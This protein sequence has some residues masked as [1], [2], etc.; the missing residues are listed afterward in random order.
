MM[1]LEL[2]RLIPLKSGRVSVHRCENQQLGLKFATGYSRYLQLCPLQAQGDLF[3][4]WEQVISLL[5]PPV[6]SKSGT[7]A[8]PAEDRTCTPAFEDRMSLDMADS[9]DQSPQ[10]GRQHRW[11]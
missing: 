1:T 9:Q 3:L 5:R 4:Y 11:L 10:Q 2:T 7:Y 8:V 6:D